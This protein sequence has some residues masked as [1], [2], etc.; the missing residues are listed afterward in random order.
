[1]QRLVFGFESFPY[2]HSLR[3]HVNIKRCYYYRVVNRYQ[4]IR[5]VYESE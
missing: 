4:V 3:F 2:I 5:L 1:M